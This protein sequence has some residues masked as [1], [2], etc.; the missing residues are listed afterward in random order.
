M[1]SLALFGPLVSADDVEQATVDTLKLWFPTYLA[2]IE[3]RTGRAPESLPAPRAW[4]THSRLTQDQGSQL[5]LGIVI[6][7]GTLDTPRRNGDGTY[8]C[9]WDVRVAIVCAAKTREESRTLA[10]IYALAVRGIVVQNSGLGGA[11]AGVDWLGE[12]NGAVPDDF[13]AA[14]WATESAFKVRTDGVVNDLV[15]PSDPDDLD[16]PDW[17]EVETAVI[18]IDKEQLP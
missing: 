8:D 17:P 13:A 6:S 7:P 4:V 12:A 3:R 16:P 11:A 10:E 9:W 1:S 14:G 18:T 2:E 15:G 5:P